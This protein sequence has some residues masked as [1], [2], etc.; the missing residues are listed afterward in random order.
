MPVTLGY[1][2]TGSKGRIFRDDSATY[3]YGKKTGV[4][5]LKSASAVMFYTIIIVCKKSILSCRLQNSFI[6]N[7]I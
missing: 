1:V 5:L 3:L 7:Q 6:K 4:F 2:L